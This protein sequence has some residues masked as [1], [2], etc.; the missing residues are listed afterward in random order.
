LGLAL[1]DDEGTKDVKEP[2]LLTIDRVPVADVIVR[3]RLRPVSEAAVASLIA[4]I[5]D[6]MVMKAPIDIG[7]MKDGKLILIAGGHRLEAAKRLGWD[8]IRANV[9]ER[10]TADWMRLMEVDDNLAGAEMTA[11]D[12]AIFLATRKE[13]YERMHPETKRGV[14]GAIGRWDAT[15]IMSVA[16]F[17]A[18]TAEKFGLSE[19]H[20][21]RLLEAGSKIRFDK[22]DALR[23]AKRPVTLKDLMDL[24]KIGDPVE[25]NAVIAS[26]AKGEARSI[27]DAR[28]AYA[29]RDGTDSA[30]QGVAET[31]DDKALKT[32]RDTWNRCSAAVRRKFANEFGEEVYRWSD[33]SAPAFEAPE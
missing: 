2:V 3:D 5:G 19:R 6:V 4:S 22:A 27:A 33:A 25:R 26:R 9:W 17:T 12:T 23:V 15:D 11:L 29:Q 20:I 24:A 1:Y 10:P 31:R 13:V 28:R 14:S 8:T 21:R 7:K 18:S 16:S 32:L 30:T